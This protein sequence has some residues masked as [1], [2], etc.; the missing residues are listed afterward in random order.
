MS[1]F[2]NHVGHLILISLLVI[3]FLLQ[4]WE[5]F[6]K[7]LKKQKTVAVSFEDREL[8]KFPTF[9][10]CDIRGYNEEIIFAATAARYKETTFDVGREVVLDKIWEDMLLRTPMLPCILC[11]PFLMGTVNCKSFKNRT[12]QELMQVNAKLFYNAHCEHCG[13]ANVLATL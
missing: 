5:Q 6:D 2:F 9:A 13:S 8:H 3:C 12:K 7:F 4:M 1:N 11:L 10:F